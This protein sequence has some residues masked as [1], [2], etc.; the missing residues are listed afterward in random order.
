VANTGLFA[1]PD[2]L[3]PFVAITGELN[4]QVEPEAEAGN[5]SKSLSA[6]ATF[7]DAPFSEIEHYVNYLD[8]H[9]PFDTHQGIKG[10]EFDRVMVVMDDTDARGFLFSYDK[11]FGAKDR[12][13]ADIRNEREGRE[14]GLDRTRRLFY[15]TCS[16]AK[17]SLVLVTYTDNPGAVRSHVLQNGWFEA[18][19]IE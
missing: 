13:A 5:L 19:E 9:S 2:S 3:K 10:L 6:L 18:H 15:V 8:E 16:R 4:G 1:V 12:T 7:L 11:L 14:T 17:K